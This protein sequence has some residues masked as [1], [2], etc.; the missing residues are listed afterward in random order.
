MWLKVMSLSVVRAMSVQ[1]ENDPGCELWQH[2][3]I[4]DSSCKARLELEGVRLRC[5]IKCHTID[6]CTNDNVLI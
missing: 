3:N 5:D 6:K 4:A 1:K 2:V